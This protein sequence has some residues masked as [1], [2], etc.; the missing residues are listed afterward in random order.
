MSP[1]L[2]EQKHIHDCVLDVAASRAGM[3][4]GYFGLSESRHD[5]AIWKLHGACNLLADANVSN[6]T[7]VAESIYD[8]PIKAVDLPDVRVAFR[9]NGLAIPPVMCVYMPGKPTQTVEKAL[10]QARQEWAT[11]AKSVDFI[12][13]IGVRPNLREEYV[14]RP[15][16]ESSAEVCYVGGETGDYIDLA[17]GLARRLGPTRPTFEDAI[18]EIIA[19]ID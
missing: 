12:T 15:I 11:W 9:R 17:K 7:I 6:M 18:D 4:I 5:L 14:W 1:A 16:L 8:G 3:R 13:V 10:T 19:R 2:Y